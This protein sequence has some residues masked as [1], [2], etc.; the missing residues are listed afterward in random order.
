MEGVGIALALIKCT[1]CTAQTYPFKFFSECPR[2]QV[3]ILLT[4]LSH[5]NTHILEDGIFMRKDITNQNY[6]KQEETPFILY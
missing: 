1:P 3:K 2:F 6:N 4:F 5:L